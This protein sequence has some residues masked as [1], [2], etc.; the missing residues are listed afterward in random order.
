MV[1]F[2]FEPAVDAE[3]F[4]FAADVVASQVAMKTEA[5]QSVVVVAAFAVDSALAQSATC[6]V[7]AVEHTSQA[8][9][10][11][12][13][14]L[15]ACLDSEM[16]LNFAE[17]GVVVFREIAEQ[18]FVGEL[19]LDI[20]VQVELTA[21]DQ[22]VE[23]SAMDSI[24]AVVL[25]IGFASVIVFVLEVGVTARRMVLEM[26]QPLGV[27]DSLLVAFLGHADVRFVVHLLLVHQEWEVSDLVV[28]FVDSYFEEASVEWVEEEILTAIEMLLELSPK[29]VDSQSAKT[30]QQALYLLAVASSF[31]DQLNHFALH[32]LV[33]I[34][35]CCC[36]WLGNCFE[37]APNLSSWLVEEV[38]CCCMPDIVGVVDIA[39]ASEAFLASVDQPCSCSP[40]VDS[41]KRNFYENLCQDFFRFEFNYI[42]RWPSWLGLLR[43]R[44]RLRIHILRY[45]ISNL[46]ERKNSLVIIWFVFMSCH[47]HQ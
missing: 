42:I 2:R 8:V 34:G 31:V 44:I 1:A 47:H 39:E 22:D 24:W 7:E 13:L 33:E 21:L 18:V 23:A 26:L 38:G 3:A 11:L 46:K 45:V 29:E 25:G 37:L 10:S 6:L 28:N 35:C 30:V 20:A 12:A 32:L 43:I 15:V 14:T 19:A 40:F 4:R 17:S 41:A 27:V 16:E 36:C 5:L 9:A